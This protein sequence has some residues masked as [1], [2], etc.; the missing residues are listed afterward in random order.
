[1]IY[2]SYILNVLILYSY[3]TRLL[4]IS[5]LDQI[6]LP[7]SRVGQIL[8]ILKETKISSILTYNSTIL[9]L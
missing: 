7:I 1:M 8:K 3:L 9:D 6:L 5:N 4:A 2:H